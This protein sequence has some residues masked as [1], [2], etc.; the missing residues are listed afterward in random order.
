MSKVKLIGFMVFPLAT[1]MVALALAIPSVAQADSPQR[2]PDSG[3]C[4][5]CHE[6]LYYLND[7]GKY[8]C[9][10][11]SPMTCVDCHSGNPLATT[12][13]EAHT[14]REAHPVI[15]ED[16]TKCQECHPEKCTE[17]VQIFK[18]VA[19]ISPVMVSAAFIPAVVIAG[20]SGAPVADH[21]QPSTIIPWQ[22]VLVFAALVVFVLIVVYI[23]RYRRREKSQH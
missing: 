1:L 7:T 17:R 5:K 21:D 18:D 16:I 9:L 12:Q 22:E 4:I 23:T 11:E 15:N 19:G 2:T 6:N 3:N 13:E 20:P 10:K 14:L 8:F